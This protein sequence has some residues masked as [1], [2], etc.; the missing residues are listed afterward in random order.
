MFVGKV[1]YFC[2]PLVEMAFRIVFSLYP[3]CWGG[4]ETDFFLPNASLCPTS[5]QLPTRF[6]SALH[7]RL[8]KRR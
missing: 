7:E 5:A 6:D 8:L 3:Y 2:S 4:P 1:H